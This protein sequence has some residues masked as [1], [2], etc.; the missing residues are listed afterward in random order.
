[1]KPLIAIA[2]IAGIVITISDV[3]IADAIG[4][5]LDG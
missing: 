5:L 1:M 4:G 2:V 3:A